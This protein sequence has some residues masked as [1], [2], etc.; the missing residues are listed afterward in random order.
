MKK[1]IMMSLAFA[2]V[3]IIAIAQNEERVYADKKVDRIEHSKK[4]TDKFV[5]RYGLN[6]S[7]ASALLELNKKYEKPRLN[8]NKAHDEG[9]FK[10]Y[11]AKDDDRNHHT[12]KPHPAKDKF[13][14][15]DRKKEMKAERKAYRKELKKILTKEQFS[16]FEKDMKG[17]KSN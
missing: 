2:S 12:R 4:R 13:E 8:R 11:D 3:S 7:Q 10:R 15:G 14:K 1:K 6:E 17:R 5:E 16:Q 9:E